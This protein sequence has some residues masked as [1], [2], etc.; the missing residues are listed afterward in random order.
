MEGKIQKKKSPISGSENNKSTPLLVTRNT[1]ERSPIQYYDIHLNG[2]IKDKTEQYSH[3]K[4]R[5]NLNIT[6]KKK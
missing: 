6:K 1:N 5:A 3:T 2:Q 4:K